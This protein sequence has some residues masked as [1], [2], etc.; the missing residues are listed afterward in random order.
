MICN[1]VPV[2][3]RA[4]C[5]PGA[6]KK[7]NILQEKRHAGEWAVGKPP[8]NLPLCIVMMLYDDCIDLRINFAGS[9]NGFVEQFAGRDLLFPD[10]VRKDHRVIVAVFL[11]SHGAIPRC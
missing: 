9:H 3:V 10:E 8:I 6:L 5:G 7:F 11:E 2:D 4:Q 1:M